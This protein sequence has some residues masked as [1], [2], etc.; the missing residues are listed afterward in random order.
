MKE[1]KVQTMRYSDDELRLIKANFAENEDLLMIMRKAFF[2]FPLD[3]DEI[4]LLQSRF[5]DENMTR[6]MRKTF[7]P[8]IQADIPLGQSIDLWMTVEMRDKDPERVMV[9]LLVRRE[10]ITR[11]EVGLECLKGV[12][13]VDFNPVISYVPNFKGDHLEEFVKVNSRNTYITHVEQQLVQLKL[14]AGLK[15]ETVEEVKDR[16]KKDSTK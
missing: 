12:I 8:E 14:L 1:K 11:I 10:L 2:Q 7:L 5:T 6:L 13:P 4:N 16:L 9:D 3:S 15:D